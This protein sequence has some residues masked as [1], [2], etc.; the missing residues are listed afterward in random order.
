MFPPF[1]TFTDKEFVGFREGDV[2]GRCL[3]EVEEV[4]AAR[5]K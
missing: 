5:T 3:D 4:A 1:P 2:V